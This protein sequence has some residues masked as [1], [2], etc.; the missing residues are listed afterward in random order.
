MEDAQLTL[1]FESGQ[2]LRDEYEANFKHGRAFVM[3][4]RGFDAL[5]PCELVL[6]HPDSEQE[7]VVAGEIVMVRDDDMLCGVGIQL[8]GV[9]AEELSRFINPGTRPSQFPG[10]ALSRHE[11][12]RAMSL[13]EQ[14]KIARQGDLNDR[15]VL[16]RLVGKSLWEA[17]LANPRITVVEVARI[18]KKGSV[19]RPLIEQIVDQAAWIQNGLVRR[20]LL[21]NPKLTTEGILKVLRV[22]PRPELKLMEKQAGYPT[23]VRDAARKLIGG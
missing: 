6:V 12:L 14:L 7:F 1:R 15:V 19:P 2:A 8:H 20:A 16:E 3:G 11:Q 13:A 5:S 4:A 18:A 22:T 21:S 9:D 10:R 23:A 17:L